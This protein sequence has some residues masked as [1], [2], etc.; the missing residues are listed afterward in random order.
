[1]RYGRNDPQDTKS[2]AHA[3]WLEFEAAYAATLAFA[4]LLGD[5]L[6]L[7]LLQELRRLDQFAYDKADHPPTDHEPE[8]GEMDYESVIDAS[9][10]LGPGFERMTAGE[11]LS[12]H[13]QL[14]PESV[15][16]AEIVDRVR[17]LS[18]AG[19]HSALEKYFKVVSDSEVHGNLIRKN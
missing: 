3:R 1:M 17:G 14:F 2:P 5:V 6:D 10:I 15:R 13:S 11:A 18:V 4:F 9:S 12:L 7:R 8:F 16:D 19:L